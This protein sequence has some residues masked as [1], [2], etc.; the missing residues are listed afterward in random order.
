MPNAL[1]DQGKTCTRCHEHRQLDEFN[2][3]S[4]ASDG[5][6]SWGTFHV[7]HDHATGKVRGLLCHRCNTKLIDDLDILRSMITYLETS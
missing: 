1:V 3:N 5:R 6:S 7:D 2:R 4:R